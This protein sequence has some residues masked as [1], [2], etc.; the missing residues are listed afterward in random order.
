MYSN[1][2]SSRIITKKQA[3]S[4]NRREEVEIHLSYKLK[5]ESLHVLNSLV[6]F[7]SLY[8]RLFNTSWSN[9]LLV[10]CFTIAV[11]PLP[12]PQQST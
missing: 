12:K 4:P 7:G 11:S 9:Q 6:P 1:F 5:D 3:T 2:I 8:W 10:F